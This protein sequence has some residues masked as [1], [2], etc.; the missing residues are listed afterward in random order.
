MIS[1]AG[2]A[3]VAKAKSIYGKRLVDSDYESMAKLKTVPE[4]ASYLRNHPN[5][6]EILQDISPDSIHRG[7]LE[8]LIRKNAFNHTLRLIKFVRVKDEGFYRLNLVRRE[9]DIILEILRDMISDSFENTISDV[10][11]YMKKNAS[12]DLFEASQSRS[13][14]ELLH[15]L[16]KTPYHEVLLPYSKVSNRD[17]D[18]V[19][20]EH[21]FDLHYFDR[22]FAEIERYY[23][24]KLRQDLENIYLSK[25]EL[26]NI[27]KIYRLKKFYH[28]DF[29][30]IKKTLIQKYSRISE[31][32]LDELIRLPEP[33]AI[34]QYL[35]KSEYQR[36]QDEKEYVYVEYFVERINYRLAK[37][38]MYYSGS[39]PKV[40]AAFLILLGIE[41]EN[42]TNIIEGIRYG[43]SEP[44]IKKMLIYG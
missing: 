13:I 39:V 14:D 12:F 25:I 3:I 31:A 34:L 10:P 42:L 27:I 43:L 9:I 37:R 19:S 26:Q 44:E 20:I 5:Y 30:T 33:E 17:I 4:V 11:Y 38:F 28:A 16:E 6:S 32:K 1:F 23:S 41:T 2:N 24:G 15:A 8:S 29:A 22:T 36:F 7:Q 35:D 40:Y 18:Y 21:A